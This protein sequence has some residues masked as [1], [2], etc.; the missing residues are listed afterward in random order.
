MNVNFSSNSSSEFQERRKRDRENNKTTYLVESTFY[1]RITCEKK[2]KKM[3]TLEYERDS[4]HSWP[5]MVAD[6]QKYE[7]EKD[8]QSHN[9]IMVSL[10]ED[11][12]YMK[13]KEETHQAKFLFFW[14]ISF[15]P[16]I[17]KWR[18]CVHEKNYK[19]IRLHNTLFMIGVLCAFNFFI[20]N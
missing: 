16:A 9:V 2:A 15:P 17:K 7:R 5:T 13:D 6:F 11:L 4:R 12:Q 19:M 1:L 18:T 20:G 8:W 14:G 3:K 10:V